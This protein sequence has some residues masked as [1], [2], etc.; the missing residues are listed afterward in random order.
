MMCVR[1]NVLHVLLFGM[2][3]ICSVKCRH[4]D[5]DK[6]DPVLSEFNNCS[7]HYWRTSWQR[8]VL[9]CEHDEKQLLC[10]KSK[11]E[12]DDIIE[13]FRLAAYGN[14][15]LEIWL[16]SKNCSEPLQMKEC[17]SLHINKSTG[18]VWHFFQED[19]REHLPFVCCVKDSDQTTSITDPT[20]STFTEFT[21]TTNKITSTTSSPSSSTSPPSLSSSTTK[22]STTATTKTPVSCRAVRRRGVLW[23]ETAPG[24]ERK[25]PCP[26][27]ST[28]IA[29]WFCEKTA[30]GRW[31]RWSHVGP[32]MS[33]CRSDE[34]NN[35]KKK[36]NAS[37][38]TDALNLL[39]D[40]F[41]DRDKQ[42]F[43]EDLAD[44]LSMMTSL[45]DRFHDAAQAHNSTEKWASVKDMIEKSASIFDRVI[46]LNTSWKDLEETR[47]SSVGTDLLSTV[48]NMGLV[49]A[50]SMLET[51]EEHSVIGKNM[52]LQ[53]VKSHYGKSMQLP[54]WTVTSGYGHRGS[55]ELERGYDK[56]LDPSQGNISVVF[57]MY[58]DLSPVLSSQHESNNKN[59]VLNSAVVS[60]TVAQNRRP[61][62]ISGKV[63]ILVEHL[64]LDANDTAC[65]FW[66][67]RRNQWDPFGCI[68]IDE[69]S[70]GTHSLCVCDHL[71][72]FAVL[73]DYKG[74]LDEVDPLPFF[75]I[76]VI[77][78]TLSIICLT[79]CVAV[80]S[81]YSY[82]SKHSWG[83]R[84]SIHRNL[85]LTL[86]IA[87]VVLVLGL[88]KTDNPRLCAVIAGALHYF[89]LS[90]FSWMLLEGVHIYMLLV[91]VFASR[92]S[93]WEKYYIFGYGFPL[94]IV[95][96]TAIARPTYYG[97][98][99]VCWLSVEKSTIWAFMGPVAFILVANIAA[100]ILAQWKA[101]NISMK[102]DNTA[103]F[104]RWLRV[105]FILFPV[106]GI[107]WI[108]GFLYVG[109]HFVVAGYLFTIF[110]SLQ[111]FSIFMCHCVMDKKARNMVLA[112]FRKKTSTVNTGSSNTGKK[113][114]NSSS[115]KVQ[116]NS[117]ENGNRIRHEEP[118]PK[119]SFADRCRKNWK[120]SPKPWKF[121]FDMPVTEPSPKPKEPRQI[122]VQWNNLK[123]R[124]VET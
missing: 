38:V 83:L 13:A 67:M 80:F 105:T 43:G 41:R 71:T 91:V 111:G 79:L 103:L 9:M 50:E 5:K 31:S 65:V 77:G 10:Y 78:C 56:Q 101:S 18:K 74:V 61:A 29:R 39:D 84:Y 93:H 24:Q 57:T 60:A 12:I 62:A 118:L 19:C 16:S 48:D 85:C 95:A 120:E 23:P 14:A 116:N 110:N 3:W 88:D 124:A 68:R 20:N 70:N 51:V 22:P 17:L 81:C 119:I 64:V 2:L 90:A 109:K 99:E 108:F 8:A 54:Q 34:I 35:L 32:D 121:C 122:V 21:S 1:S 26:G 104:K 75:Y 44:V 117:G 63:N 106:L 52:A 30:F 25:Q 33:G 49:L 69:A 112:S 102:D 28:G 42:I 15:E 107:T 47:R 113:Q 100:L 94:I 45:P 37:T 123:D 76:T 36:F 6:N 97:T 11:Q 55:I 53:V 86:L 7:F 72:N 87:N 73:M 27:N 40:V 96:I 82:Y 89:F 114:K 58:S 4:K 66:N 46:E 98:D 59:A 92:R 115:N